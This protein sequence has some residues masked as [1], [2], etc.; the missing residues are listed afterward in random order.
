MAGTGTTAFV[1]HCI[2]IIAIST[3]FTV[4]TCCVPQTFQALSCE[5]ITVALFLR[6]YIAMAFTRSTRLS[7]Y[8]R[9][10]IVAISTPFTL[11]ASIA[12]KTFVTDNSTFFTQLT[13]RTEIVCSR[14]QRTCTGLAVLR[15]SLGWISIEARHA[16]ITERSCCVVLTSK[17]NTMNV[18]LS[19]MPI[20][21]AGLTNTS[22]EYSIH[23]V[24]PRETGLT[25]YSCV[26]LRTFTEFHIW[27]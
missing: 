25:G 8:K 3:L 17:A 21:L 1:N 19:C 26:T 18:T 20:A 24:V 2:P 4:V 23:T 22:K 10:P 5:R 15:C 14:T 6:V 7:R 11:R 12:W 27:C 13:S 9:I 16:L